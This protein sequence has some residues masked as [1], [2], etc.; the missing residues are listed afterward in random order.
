VWVLLNRLNPPSRFNTYDKHGLKRALKEVV[1]VGMCS[2]ERDFR[3]ENSRAAREIN[4]VMSSSLSFILVEKLTTMTPNH[5]IN[6]SD[7]NKQVFITNLSILEDG[8][9]WPNPGHIL[10]DPVR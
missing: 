6:H 4:I 8:P 7:N 3:P 9:F 10:A 1:V 5:K 2:E